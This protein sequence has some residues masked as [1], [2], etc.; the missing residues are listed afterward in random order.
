MTLEELY[1][2][3]KSTGL[4][5]AYSHFEE[6]KSPPY[7]TYLSVYSSNLYADDKV[8]K[9][10]DN[11]QIELYT[12]K[13]DLAVEKILEDILDENEIAYDTTEEWINSEKLF[14]RIYEVR[15]I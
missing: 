14:Q 5:V 8:Y 2:L 10:I 1:I 11:I 3:L 9:K 13:K 7:I 6:K 15:L 4:P 12:N